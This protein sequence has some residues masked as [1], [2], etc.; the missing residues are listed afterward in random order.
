MGATGKAC[1]QSWLR[2]HFD[3][4]R[5]EARNGLMHVCIA[6]VLRISRSKQLLYPVGCRESLS[7]RVGSRACTVVPR[8][9]SDWIEKLPF[10]AFKRSSI[11]VSPRPPICFA[12]A[13]SKPNPESFTVRWISPEAPHNRTS[14]RRTP[15]C[16]TEL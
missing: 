1:W 12:I 6:Y 4:T 15:L 9:G 11:L 3:D 10:K 7:K 14:K 5:P 2:A 16:F 13:V 8:F